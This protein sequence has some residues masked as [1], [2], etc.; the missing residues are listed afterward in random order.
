MSDYNKDKKYKSQG[1][2]GT[3][4]FHTLLLLFLF[5]SVLTATRQEEEGLL[6]NY[7]YTPDG[8]GDTEPAPV[9]APVAANVPPVAAQEAP[10][11]AP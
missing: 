1:F 9:K 7:G 5:S 3:A 2:L 8:S 6:V 4:I 11:P 10:P